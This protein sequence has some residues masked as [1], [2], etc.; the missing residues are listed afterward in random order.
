MATGSFTMQAVEYPSLTKRDRSHVLLACK[1][2]E[3]SNL[4]QRHGCVIAVGRHV[5]STG[6][7]SGNGLKRSVHAEQ[8]AIHKIRRRIKKKKNHK[9]RR[10]KRG[11]T[12]YIIRLDNHNHNELLMSAPCRECTTVI[13]RNPFITRIVYSDGAGNFSIVNATDYE[14]DHVARARRPAQCAA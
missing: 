2:A 1:E 13:K 7:N 11:A 14:T 6:H 8:S 3:K 4:P 12:I 5:L 10:R 9:I